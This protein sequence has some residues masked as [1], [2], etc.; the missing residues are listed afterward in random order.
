[1]TLYAGIG[2]R[3]TPEPI[4][5]SM[6]RIAVRLSVSGYTLR[7]GGARGADSAFANVVSPERKEIFGAADATKAAM[8]IAAKHHPAWQNCDELARKLHGRNAMIIMGAKLNKP[9]DF[10]VCWTPDGI[11]A[12]GTGLGMRIAWSLKIPVYNLFYPEHA[13][14]LHKRI[15]E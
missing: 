13:R 12:G 9:V 4:L 3:A 2:A 7:S 11:D 10:V 5:R 1:M 6:S 15:I 14:N 8:A